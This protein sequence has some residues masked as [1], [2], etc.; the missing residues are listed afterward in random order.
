MLCWPIP[1]PE[2]L[3]YAIIEDSGT[4]IKVTPGEILS[5][6]LRELPEGARRLVFDKVLAIGVDGTV[7]KLG[8]PYLKGAKVTGEL[9]GTEDAVDELTVKT[10]STKYSRRKG[11][12]R[13]RGQKQRYL[14]VKIGEIIAA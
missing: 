2:Q 9:M 12:R 10:V 8:A 6:D 14:R 7:A 4:Q 3:V 5:I 1:H 13:K 11:W